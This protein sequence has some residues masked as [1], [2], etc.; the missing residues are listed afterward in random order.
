MSPS[1]CVK[2]TDMLKVLNAVLKDSR[3]IDKVGKQ[4]LYNPQQPLS[5][6]CRGRFT[7]FPQRHS[8]CLRLKS[9]M[10]P[11]HHKRGLDNLT[12]SSMEYFSSIQSRYSLLLWPLR[13]LQFTLHQFRA[14]DW[15]GFRDLMVTFHTIFPPMIITQKV[16][17]TERDF[18][19]ISIFG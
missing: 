4:W 2:S 15:D 13:Q 17:G 1:S 19:Y 8:S 7:L 3:H 14:F 9:S 16:K 10:E 6:E 12:G 18:F 5:A 11:H